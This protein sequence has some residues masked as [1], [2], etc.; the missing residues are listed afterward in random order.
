MDEFDYWRLCDELNATQAGALIV[1]ASPARVRCEQKTHYLSATADDST[2]SAETPLF[3]AAFSAIKNAI[4]AGTLKATVRHSARE[5]GEIDAQSDIDH[6]EIFDIYKEGS[7]AGEDEVYVSEHS[8][9]YKPFPDW[10]LTTISVEDLRR[11]LASRGLSKGFFFPEEKENQPG[12][13]DEKHPCYA[14]KL[15]A[16]IRAWESVTSNQEQLRGKTPKAA[17][18]KWL[19]Q[20][21]ASY[22]LTKDDG[23]PNSQGV[24]EAAKVAN[25]K[26]EGGASKTPSV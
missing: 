26:R 14:P 15:A 11:W 7:T 2:P 1:G 9:F 5:Y 4:G 23:T 19:N 6:A 16:A 3:Q 24:E 13:L 22:Q 20:N 12:Y 17:L 25:W 8:C 21:A 18:M 10:E